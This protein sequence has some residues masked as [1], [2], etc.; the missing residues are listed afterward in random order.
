[1]SEWHRRQVD[2][3]EGSWEKKKTK[4]LKD[5]EE[6]LSEINDGVNRKN[7]R[8]IGV[9]EGN[10]KDRGAEGVSEQNVAENFPNIGRETG[11]QIQ[12]IERFHPNIIKIK[13]KFNTSKFNR[14]TCK[15]QR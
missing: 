6:R 1:M 2:G 14:E 15:L 4:Q 12:E 10:E 9:P 7:T 11:I 13:S 8:L 3:K 5:R